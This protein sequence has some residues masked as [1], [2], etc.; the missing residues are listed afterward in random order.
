[1]HLHALLRSHVLFR[2]HDPSHFRDR[3]RVPCQRLSEGGRR[4]R[5]RQERARQERARQDWPRQEQERERWELGRQ[6]PERREPERERHPQAHHSQPATGHAV[7]KHPLDLDLF[8]SYT[9]P[10]PSAPALA[11]PA[12]GSAPPA[13]ERSLSSTGP[14][15]PS[16]IERNGKSFDSALEV[17][18]RRADSVAGRAGFDSPLVRA[19]IPSWRGLARFLGFLAIVRAGDCGLR[20]GGFPLPVGGECLLDFQSCSGPL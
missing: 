18:S 10:A 5:A 4:E 3:F 1:M 17:A 13:K 14:A 11:P 9:G 16:P 15:A 6:E 19:L 20:V 7:S 12:D 2:F 8:P